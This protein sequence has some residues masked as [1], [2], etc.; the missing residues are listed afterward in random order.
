MHEKYGDYLILEG[1]DDYQTG[2]CYLTLDVTWQQEL[3]FH[4]FCPP[5]GRGARVEY[6]GHGVSLT[7]HEWYD[8][9][10]LMPAI[11]MTNPKFLC[12]NKRWDEFLDMMKSPVPCVCVC[13]AVL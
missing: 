6:P 1:P 5:V 3:K 4:S 13:V 12:P 8:W 10:R 11:H 2:Q 7:Q 9:V